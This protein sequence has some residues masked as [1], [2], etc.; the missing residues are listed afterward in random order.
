MTLIRKIWWPGQ[1][2]P[3]LTRRDGFSL[4]TAGG[5]P[6]VTIHSYAADAQPGVVAL[7]NTTD[8]DEL[9]AAW[10]KPGPSSLGRPVVPFYHFLGRVPPLK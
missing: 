10:R 7:E 6:G 4:S 5:L 2:T 9:F 8:V 3:W 1:I